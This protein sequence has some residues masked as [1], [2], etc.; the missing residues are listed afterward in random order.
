M[1]IVGVHVSHKRNILYGF[2]LRTACSRIGRSRHVVPFVVGSFSVLS[3]C[4]L[5]Q[6]PAN[7]RKTIT[8]LIHTNEHMRIC[9]CEY[10]RI[11]IRTYA[12][13]YTH[14]HLYAHT[15]IFIRTYAY[16]YPHIRVYLFAY[17]ARFLVNI[18]LS[19]TVTS[20]LLLLLLLS[21]SRIEAMCSAFWSS[22]SEALCSTEHYGPLKMRLYHRAKHYG[23][24]KARLKTMAKSQIFIPFFN[25]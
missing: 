10:I 12:Y 3:S 6:Q 1:F 22:E 13:I 14:I 5:E 7:N 8:L 11:I 25:I 24:L 16:T 4:S 18:Y 2:V 20:Q 19:R 9:V 23:L 21:L 15:R 17:H